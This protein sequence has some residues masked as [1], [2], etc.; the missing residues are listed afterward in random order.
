MSTK[1]KP[2]PFCEDDEPKVFVS[3][4]YPGTQWRY[5]IVACPSCKGKGPE[6]NTQALS[7]GGLTRAKNKAIKK[8]DEAWARR[9]KSA[10]E[11]SHHIPAWSED[12]LPF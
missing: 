11:D 4:F 9:Q 8:W 12:Y 3:P 10:E 1:P 6:V 2:C 5:V 7:K